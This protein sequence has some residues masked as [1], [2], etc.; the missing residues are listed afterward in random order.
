MNI[1]ILN[2]PINHC[3]NDDYFAKALSIRILRNDPVHLAYGAFLR[4]F[5]NKKTLT[6]DDILVGAHMIYGWMPTMLDMNVG[7]N[8]LSEITDLL[9]K[10]KSGNK[11]SY[12]EI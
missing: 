4:F 3:R 11:L 8:R 9:N 7:D 12:Q 6:A 1:N 10:V 2:M 5:E